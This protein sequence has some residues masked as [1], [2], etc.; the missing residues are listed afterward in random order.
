MKRILLYLLIAFIFTNLNSQS[1][2]ENPVSSTEDEFV[3]TPFGPALK[4]NI[5]YIDNK[6]FINNSNGKIQ[7]I[8]K[9]TGKVT[10][11][12]ND[13]SESKGSMQDTQTD[14]SNLQ[15]GWITCADALINDQNA[16]PIS[17][18]SANWE[19]PFPPTNNSRQ[20]IYIFNGLDGSLGLYGQIVQPVL[21]WGISPAGGGNY[22]SICNWYVTHEEYFHDSLIIVQPE[23]SLKGIIKLTSSTDSLFSYN[24]SFAGYPTSLQINNIPV[25]YSPSIALEVYNI[26][27]CYNYPINEKLRF[28]NIQIKV[29]GNENP[30]VFWIINNF[31][32]DCGQFTEIIHD[33][34]NGELCIHFHTASAIE[35]FTDIHFYPNPAKD[36]IY[37]SPQI[38]ITNCRIDLLNSSGKLIF[39]NFYKDL[40]DGTNINLDC[41]AY[42]LY[43]LKFTYNNIS[44]T[45]KIIKVNNR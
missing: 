4:S 36:F 34:N 31:V 12:Y 7:V 35:N 39:T 23:T 37:V 42:G 15:D 20:L 1:I 44:R 21:Q 9:E 10:Q 41:Y 40:S 11:E 26:K 18:F 6:H 38:P 30:P 33:S 45:F 2:Q 28:T 3:Y 29:E 24:S 19:V 17:F 32:S 25:L 27:E 22:W 8:Q 43:F 14:N 5:H 13:I 16:G